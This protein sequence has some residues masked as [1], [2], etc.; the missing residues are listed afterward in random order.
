VEH[1]EIAYALSVL[2][3]ESANASVVEI[4]LD[5]EVVNGHDASEASPVLK[6]SRAL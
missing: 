6:E 2:A 5:E 1:W 3:S 4:S